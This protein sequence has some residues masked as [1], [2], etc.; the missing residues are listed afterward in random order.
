MQWLIVHEDEIDE[1]DEKTAGRSYGEL[2]IQR[3]SGGKRIEVMNVLLLMNML[4]LELT[5]WLFI[6]GRGSTR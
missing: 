1:E 4:L 6:I 3:E 5:M 2:E